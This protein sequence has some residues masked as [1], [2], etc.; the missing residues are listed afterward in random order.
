MNMMMKSKD[1][2]KEEKLLK[3]EEKKVKELQEL[4]LELNTKKKES[5]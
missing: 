4:N 3:I 2:S 5:L 1:P